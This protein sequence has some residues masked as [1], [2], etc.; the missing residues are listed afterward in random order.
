MHRTRLTGGAVAA[1]AVAALSSWLRPQPRDRR[2]RCSGRTSGSAAS[3]S[4]RGRCSRSTSTRSRPRT[5][6][7][8]AARPARR[9]PRP[10][11]GRT[12]TRPTT[13]RRPTASRSTSTCWSGATSSRPG[14]RRCPPKSSWSRSRSGSRP[15]RS[16]TRTS[17]GCR[18]STSR[19]TIRPTA[20]TRP[21]RAATATP[22]ATTRGRSGGAN[23]TDGTG[24]D[25]ILNAFRLAKQYFPNTK[26]ML[27]D[28]SITNSDTA[29][30][31]YLQIINI[32][33]RENLLDVI[34]EQG[35]A[36]S[37][38]GNMAVHKAQ[39]RSPRRDRDPDPDHRA[40][41]RRAGRRRRRRR[42]GPAAR[43]PPDRPGLLGAPRASRASRSGAGASPTTGATPRTRRS[44]SPPT[45]PSPPRCGSTTTCAGSRRSIK[46]DQT[47]SVSDVNAPGRHRRRPTTGPRRSAARSCGPSRG[48]SP[49]SDGP[50]A[51]DPEHRRAAHHGPAAARREHDLHAQGARQRRLPHVRARSRSRSSRRISPN[52]ADGDAGGTV[53]AT[54]ALALGGQR[55]LRR[56]SRPAWRKD[57]EATDD[58]QRHQHRG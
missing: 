16:A 21:T 42:R 32:L 25:W 5:R 29:T 28:Y 52:V 41:H 8:G 27:N 1:I 19:C 11:A 18:S 55:R 46:A 51:I 36:F 20:R 26:L 12:S 49:S 23:G 40:R 38:T 4:S 33:K 3:T 58:R 13:S 56:R 10:C 6:A 43:L 34:G 31:Q 14:W 24:W 53:P 17:S 22:A 54:L 44:C 57:Y 48:S 7:S 35:H 45:R 9:A 39:P 37:T 30:T 47:F 15:S 2:S 50:F